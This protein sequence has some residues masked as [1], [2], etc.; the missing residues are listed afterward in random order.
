MSLTAKT[1]EQLK[2]EAEFTRQLEAYIKNTGGKFLYS[3]VCNLLGTIASICG[4]QSQRENDDWAKA[5]RYIE[6]CAADCD[7]KYKKEP[8]DPNGDAWEERMIEK[9]AQE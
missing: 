2:A 3:G 5:E 7:V 4:E 1:Q 8:P 9:R 6:Q